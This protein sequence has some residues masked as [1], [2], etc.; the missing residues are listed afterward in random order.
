[1]N[2]LVK[3]GDRPTAPAEQESLPREGWCIAEA[4]QVRLMATGAVGV[5][6]GLPRS[7]LLRVENAGWGLS[8]RDADPDNADKPRPE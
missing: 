1:M 8:L 4:G 2:A 7:G 5:E 3:V 6:S